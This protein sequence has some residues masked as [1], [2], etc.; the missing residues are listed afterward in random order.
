V[1]EM[2]VIVNDT[3]VVEHPSTE[4]LAQTENAGYDVKHVADQPEESR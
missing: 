2:A 3:T 4:W 1:I